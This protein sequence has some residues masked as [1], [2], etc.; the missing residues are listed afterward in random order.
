MYQNNLKNNI[1]HSLDNLLRLVEIHCWNKI[2][3]NIIFILSD[4]NEF[5]GSNSSEQRI[6]RNKLNNLKIPLTLDAAI[7]VLNNEYDDLYDVN[8]Y[9]FKALKKETIIEIQYYR[10][11]NFETAY[12]TKIKNNPPM[13]HAKFSL[14]FFG[15]SG[16]QYDVNWEASGRLRHIWSVFLYKLRLK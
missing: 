1:Q 15:K 12:Y 5:K 10:K 14:P 6:H 4:F 11:S 16:V 13:F 3:P 7:Q 9:V 2:S 8:L